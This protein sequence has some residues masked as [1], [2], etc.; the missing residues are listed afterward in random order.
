MC[1]QGN[2][3]A[4]INNLNA[5]CLS[6]YSSKPDHIG[7]GTVLKTNNVH[8]GKGKLPPAPTLLAL[9]SYIANVKSGMKK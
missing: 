6:D 5:V 7:D 4:N 3:F 1:F 9:P 2:A 8:G